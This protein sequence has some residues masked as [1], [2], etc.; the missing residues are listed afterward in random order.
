MKIESGD[1]YTVDEMAEI[2]GVKPRTIYM[3]LFREGI[4]PVAPDV[5][6]DKEAYLF[7]KNTQSPG[8]PVKNKKNLKKG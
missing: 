7:V 5:I 3:R 6:Y 8:R 1:Y 2:E 4:K